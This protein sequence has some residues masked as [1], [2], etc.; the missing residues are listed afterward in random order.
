[1]CGMKVKKYE[2]MKVLKYE[3]VVWVIWWIK[4]C[5]GIY[6]L[7]K[8]RPMISKE[9]ARY[10]YLSYFKI[11]GTFEIFSYYRYEGWFTSF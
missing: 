11:S 5:G 9:T 2:S 8:S 7:K 10:T 4:E 6:V 3:R 1:M